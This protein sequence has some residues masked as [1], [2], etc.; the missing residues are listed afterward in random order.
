MHVSVLRV[1]MRYRSSP[2]F[3]GVSLGFSLSIPPHFLAKDAP[4]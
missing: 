1:K 3:C 2:Q 4:E